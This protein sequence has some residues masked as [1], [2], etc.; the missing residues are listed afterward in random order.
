MIRLSGIRIITPGPT[1]GA[2]AA[3]DELVGVYHDPVAISLPDLAL[4]LG[5]VTPLRPFCH[6]SVWR[7]YC[8]HR[9]VLT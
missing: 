9:G 4:G 1:A 6:Y 7:R 5:N 8:E 3:V 2:A